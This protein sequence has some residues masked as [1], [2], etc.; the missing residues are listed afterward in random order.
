MEEPE[1]VHASVR[2]VRVSASTAVPSH[3]DGEIQ[4]LQTEFEIEVLPEALQLL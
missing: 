1:I 2:R 4:P 3:L